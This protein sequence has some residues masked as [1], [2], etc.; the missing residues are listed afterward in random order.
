MFINANYRLAPDK[1]DMDEF[2]SVY[3]VRGISLGHTTLQFEAS[4]KSS[5]IVASYPRDIQVFPP[6]RLEPRNITLI[7]G[8]I[9]QVCRVI[10]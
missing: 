10:P 3:T 6:L 5:K 1:S 9:F 2:T 8:A 4:Q 7:V